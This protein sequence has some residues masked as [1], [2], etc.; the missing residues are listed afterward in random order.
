MLPPFR[1]TQ[2]S[3]FWPFSKNPRESWIVDRGN[4]DFTLLGLPHHLLDEISMVFVVPWR[5]GEG[6]PSTQHSIRPNF[7]WGF[8][9]KWRKRTTELNTSWSNP[10]IFTCTFSLL[11]TAL[12]YAGSPASPH[13]WLCPPTVERRTT[14]WQ[15][16]IRRATSKSTGEKLHN[17]NVQMEENMS[18]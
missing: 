7:S 3:G 16:S 17:G 6:H 14:S 1:S 13:R 9:P 15:C 5:I 8:E 2:C 18:E 4:L 10:N 11:Q 12:F